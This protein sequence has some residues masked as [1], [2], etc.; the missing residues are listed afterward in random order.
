[1]FVLALTYVDSAEPEELLKLRIQMM[2]DYGCDAQACDFIGWCV[3]GQRLH[4]DIPY[5]VKRFDLLTRLGNIAE[6]GKQVDWIMLYYFTLLS[7]VFFR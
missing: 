4:H 5:L 6:F 1:M 3:R 7:C 2:L